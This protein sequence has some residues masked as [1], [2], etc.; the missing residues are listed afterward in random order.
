MSEKLLIY[1]DCGGGAQMSLPMPR[2]NGGIEWRLRYG[3]AADVRFVAASAL[4]SYSYLTSKEISMAEATR[5]LR[6]LRK[7]KRDAT[8]T[9]ERT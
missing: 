9:P 3:S 2:L 6:L 5:R 1:V 8:P 7:A 4:E